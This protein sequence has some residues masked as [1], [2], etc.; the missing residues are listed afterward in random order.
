MR[1]LELSGVERQLSPEEEQVVGTE[2]QVLRE[3]PDTVLPRLE[4]EERR[5]APLPAR[6]RAP[7]PPPEKIQ[8][9]VARQ[10]L[11]GWPVLAIDRYEGADVDWQ[12]LVRWDIPADYNGD[13]HQIALLSDDDTHTRYR[14]IIAGRE[15]AT[16]RDKQISTPVTMPW[17]GNVIPGPTSVTIEVRS[18]VSGTTIKVDAFITGTER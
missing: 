11:S 15:Q 8:E 14:I 16:P 9:E 12:M 4:E 13:L 17:R 1:E 10:T 3:P 6:A 5:V 18:T 7:L 2:G